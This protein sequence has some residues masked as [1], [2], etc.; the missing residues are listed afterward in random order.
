[1]FQVRV[2]F[3]VRDGGHIFGMFD[4]RGAAEDCLLIV[5]GRP[6]VKSASIEPV[7]P[8]HQKGKA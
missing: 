7:E 6:D 3:D 4:K 5:A 2:H 1:M 8:N